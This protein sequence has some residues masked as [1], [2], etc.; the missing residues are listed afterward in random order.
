MPSSA[1]ETPLTRL[2]V[3][4]WSAQTRLP[5]STSMWENVRD[6]KMADIIPP[7]TEPV[8][9]GTRMMFLL[10]GWS[11][12]YSDVHIPFFNILYHF[13]PQNFLISIELFY[14]SYRIGIIERELYP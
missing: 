12:T 14:G 6:A 5:T 8:W 1:L 11:A 4:V 3:D 7:R 10:G 13:M 9:A 2:K